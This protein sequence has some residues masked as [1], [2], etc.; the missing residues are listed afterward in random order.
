MV[1]AA[2]FPRDV[3]KTAV[4]WTAGGEIVGGT[5]V[6]WNGSVVADAIVVFSTVVRGTF[7][8]VVAVG[9]VCSNNVVK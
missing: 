3:V 7:A 5:V 1:G 8:D 9:D 4:D 6:A 2:L